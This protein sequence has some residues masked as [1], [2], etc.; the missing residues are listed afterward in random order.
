[1]LLIYLITS[2]FS[3]PFTFW[4]T[5]LSLDFPIYSHILSQ[6]I[7]HLARSDIIFAE[8]QVLVVVKWPKTIQNRQ[9][10][11]TI[12]LPILGLSILCPAKALRLL[13]ESSSGHSNALLFQITWSHGAVPLKTTV[14]EIFFA[15]LYRL[16]V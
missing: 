12:S 15:L 14:H 4:P 13:L 1:M 3:R 16:C 9:D 10:I 6:V 5:F 2:I 8:D 7:R 11:R